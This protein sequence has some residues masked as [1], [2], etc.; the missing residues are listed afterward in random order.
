MGQQFTTSLRTTWNDIAGRFCE[1]RECLA[2]Y[3]ALE[4]AEVI[5]GV[6]PANLI[7]IPNRTRSCGSN[8]YRYWKRW[9]HEVAGL[10]RLESCT[11]SERQ[12]S[13]LVLLYNAE[14]LEKLIET[15]PVR[16]MLRKAGY[17]EHSDVTTVLTRLAGRMTNGLF[18][19]EIGIILGYPL[20][21]VAGFMGL[22]KLP[23]ACQGPWKIYGDPHASLRLAETYR[24]SR[25][26]MAADLTVCSSPFDCL[27]KPAAERLFSYL[28]N[29]KDCQLQDK[30]LRNPSLRLMR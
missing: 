6:K 27:G 9:G 30:Y 20:K 19:H 16:A 24:S 14:A 8:M 13:V 2:A 10:A 5:A 21:D 4:T 17:P 26:R 22:A 29:D 11:L 1:P 23:F 3:L 25:R 28:T 18:P 15:T 7:S 12:D